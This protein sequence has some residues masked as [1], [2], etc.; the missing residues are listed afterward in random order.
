[1]LLRDRK[2]LLTN[3][4]VA[5]G[6]GV[7]LTVVTIW[8]LQWWNP[9][10]YKFPPIVERGSW[11]WNVILVN[12]FFLCVRLGQRSRFVRQVHGWKQAMLAVPRQVWANIVNV[13]AVSR[14]FRVFGRSLATG[15]S[16]AWDKTRHTFPVGATTLVDAPLGPRD[17]LLEL[18]L[19]TA[20]RPSDAEY[21]IVQALAEQE[22]L[23]FRL[24]D[25]YSIP[26]NVLESFPMAI[27]VMHSSI[28]SRLSSRSVCH[29]ESTPPASHKSTQRQ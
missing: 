23:P 6:Y 16:V 4:T 5:L 3:P 19:R 13:A 22:R 18:P 9:D 29:S 21:E 12:T 10:F 8:I 17:R 26:Q 2:G 27:A 28:G 24:V 11:L 15:T 20:F 14:A 25:P 7:V 1:V